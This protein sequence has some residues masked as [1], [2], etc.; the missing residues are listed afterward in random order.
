MSCLTAFASPTYVC[1]LPCSSFHNPWKPTQGIWASQLVALYCRSLAACTVLGLWCNNP[2]VNNLL[3]LSLVNTTPRWLIFSTC[4]KK[5]HIV[6][7]FPTFLNDWR[8]EMTSLTFLLTFHD[9]WHVLSDLDFCILRSFFILVT[10]F[11]QNTNDEIL[12]ASWKSHKNKR[13]FL[14]KLVKNQ[15]F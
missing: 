4:C 6:E 10:I 1:Q 2:C 11:L 8:L 3:F 9:F 15:T 14:L 13:N 12:L 5:S 7:K